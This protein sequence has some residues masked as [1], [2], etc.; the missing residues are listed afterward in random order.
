MLRILTDPGLSYLIIPV[1]RCVEK[2]LVQGK[3]MYRESTDTVGYI[4]MWDLLS[5]TA[6]QAK[7]VAYDT[8]QKF[9]NK[10]EKS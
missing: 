6:K 8:P 5:V 9:Y 2:I 10:I 4:F 3:H 7:R 1:S